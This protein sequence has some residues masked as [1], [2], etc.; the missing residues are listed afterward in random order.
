MVHAAE[1][2]QRLGLQ[3]RRDGREQDLRD[4]RLAPDPHLGLR[5]V[6]QQ[7]LLHAGLQ[8]RQGHRLE[9]QRLHDRERRQQRELVHAARSGRRFAPAR[10]GGRRLRR[11]R[12]G[13]FSFR[14]DALR[15][16]SLLELRRG[17]CAVALLVQGDAGGSS[18]RFRV[19][20]KRRRFAAFLPGRKDR[21]RRD[22]EPLRLPRRNGLRRRPALQ[23]ACRLRIVERGRRVLRCT[24]PAA[25]R[26]ARGRHR[27]L[28]GRRVRRERLLVRHGR[29][30]GE[31][32]RRGPFRFDC[33][34]E[35]D[36][37]RQRDGGRLVLRDRTRGGHFLHRPRHGDE[38]GGFRDGGADRL[39]HDRLRR[40]GVRRL[41][42]S[43]RHLELRHALS[44]AVLARRGQL[45]RDRRVEPFAV[46]RHARERDA[47][48]RHHRREDRFRHGSRRRDDLH[49]HA[50][51]DGLE[52]HH[53]LEDLHV[54][55]RGS[56]PARRDARGRRR[57]LHGRRVHRE[58]LLVRHGR[59]F[60][61]RPAR[62]PFRFD[63]RLEPDQDR[64][65][66]GRRLLLRDRTCG[67]HVLLRPRHG[68]EHGGFRFPGA[69]LV[70]DAPISARAWRA[71]RHLQRH[72]RRP[73]RC[74]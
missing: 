46:D 62:S 13:A 60:G 17:R 9:H 71:R 65:R 23:L 26:D 74:R 34:L 47:L 15:A 40:A 20:R 56:R 31:R 11:A 52:R 29:H 55:H 37:D 3:R 10:F 51:G 73:Q 2:L 24:P 67:G 22:R 61:D 58:R 4:R 70:R 5:L 25:C 30:F 38:F 49:R 36:Q 66:D 45:L 28:H 8:S 53:R 44:R 21:D 6:G 27:R 18:R 42:S 69:D 19:D 72:R 43:E 48:L 35:P 7:G 64:Q 50:R 54:P 41:R 33:R 32:A 63:R 59:L 57:R 14:H 39:L 1:R 16:A 68:D 12:R